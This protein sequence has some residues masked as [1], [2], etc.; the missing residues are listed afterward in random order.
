MRKF[1]E[2]SPFLFPLLC[3]VLIF[4]FFPLIFTVYISF[5]PMKNWNISHYFHKF[6]GLENYERLFYMFLHDPT[7]K[8][9]LITTLVFV[10]ITL[11]I[12]VF[13]GLF[14]AFSTFFLEEKLSSFFQLFWLF[15]RMAPIAVYSLCWYYFFHETSIG[16]LNSILMKLHLI[17]HPIPWGQIIPWGAWSIIIFVNGLVGVSFGMIIF[18]SA[19]NQIPKELIIA[20]RIDG[21]GT[22]RIS[23][24]IFFPL[25]R[26]HF[27][28]VTI[29][30]F[31]SLLTTYCHL[32]LLVEWNLVDTN[33]GTTLS[34]YIFNTSFGTQ[35][36]YQGLAAAA[37]IILSIIGVLWGFTALKVLNFEKMM[38]PPKGEF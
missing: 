23:K 15:P 27:M 4:Y 22:F 9:V 16:T 13:G 24:D 29:W 18:S 30:Q 31:L 37:S 14:L 6:I 11:I 17:S 12:N 28:Y 5:T 26:W 34:L 7:F 2:V 36:Q 19:I 10:G 8:I 25:I 32:F 3:L 1:K 35:E 33:Y 38:K 21:A 20:A